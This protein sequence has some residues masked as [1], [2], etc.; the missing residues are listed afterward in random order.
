LALEAE[1]GEGV[2]ADAGALTESVTAV[3]A[4]C[5]STPEEARAI[6]ENLVAANLAG[7]DSHGVGM[8][9]LYV[10]NVGNGAVYAN[11]HVSVLKDN[12]PVVQLDGNL[13]YGQVI[14]A[15][16]MAIGIAK[17]KEAGVAILALRNTHH[18][19]R[20]GAWAEL[21]ADAG[22]VS[23]HYVNINGHKPLVAPF[24]GSEGRYATNPYC[25]AIPGTDTQPPI[26]LDMATSKV[27]MGKVRVAHN[28]GKTVADDTLIDASGVATNDPAAMFSDPRGALLPFGDHKGYGL[29]LI[30]EVLAGALVNGGG[31]VP[32][33]QSRES[34]INNMLSIVLDPAALGDVDFF[35]S[36]LDEITRYVKS[37]APAEGV[38]AVMVPGD[39][40]RKQ[41]AAR[42]AD[43]I[44]IDATT[45]QEILAAAESVGVMASEITI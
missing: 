17:A 11:Q 41:R 24:G 26:V 44:A 35:R 36:E 42:G 7:H 45:W 18:L 43:G 6:A 29:A 16:A 32:Q 13:G 21:C 19:G 22:L 10:R 14:G 28:T 1:G 8:V 4:A 15:E 12:G 5:G 33:R 30:C 40:E 9:P 38:E 2:I 34:V 23:I 25:T 3:F 31:C 27:A 39:P 20:I 37:S